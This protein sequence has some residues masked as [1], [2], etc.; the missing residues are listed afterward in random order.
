[1]VKPVVTGVTSLGLDHVAVLGNTIKEIAGQKGGIYKV[2]LLLLV[3][4]P[5]INTMR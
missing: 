5:V 1:M 3:T 2:G 4:V